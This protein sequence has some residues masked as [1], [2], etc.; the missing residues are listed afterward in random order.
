MHPLDVAVLSLYLLLIL[1]L[2]VWFAR[3]GRGTRDYFRGGARMPW[4]A[5]GASLL[6]T[7]LSSLT[8]MGIPAKVYHTNWA[9]L[10]GALAPVLIVPLVTRCYLPFFRKL[11]VT[12]AYEYLEK[13]FSRSVRLLGAAMFAGFHLTRSAVLLLM[14]ALALHALVDLPVTA[15][16]LLLG[17]FCAAY[18]LL[19]G[20]EAVIWTDVLQVI[21]LTGGAVAALLVVLLGLEGGAAQVV[22]V[23]S[24]QGKFALANPGWSPFE[25]SAWVILVGYSIGMLGPYTAD[26]TLVQRYLTTSDQRGAARAI[27][28][29]VAGYIPVALVFYFLGTAMWVYYQANPG[30]LPA[31]IAPDAVVPH[32]LT[33]QLPAG[34]SGLAIAGIVAAAMSTL[35]SSFNSIATSVVTDWLPA[36]EGS[37][38]DAGRMRLARGVTLIAGLLTTLGALLAVWLAVHTGS[39]LDVFLMLLG[40]T[41]PMAGLF[42]LGI[43]TRRTNAAG[44]WA[45]TVLGT[46]TVLVVWQATEVS[47]F[48]YPPIGLGVSLVTGYVASWIA[49]PEET[50]L[51]LTVAG[52]RRT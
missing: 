19:G 38:N 46:A 28:L 24:A 20:I 35:D 23:G 52:L 10:V 14:P 27:W 25:A 36:R 49:A 42:A 17:L 29:G 9:Y 31:D 8:Y 13:R 6:A 26:Q 15:G 12:S 4:W 39:L 11:D 21:V 50:D 3:R 51:S 1:A 18:T 34:L 7:W 22:E 40:I 33:H 30:L 48:L 37:E 41:G 2:G 16:V 32:F 47:F 43:F 45:G 5:A 44:A